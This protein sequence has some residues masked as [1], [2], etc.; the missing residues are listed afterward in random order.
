MKSLASFLFAAVLCVALL[1]GCEN[2]ELIRC[3]QDKD[4]L[5]EELN[6]TKEEIKTQKASIDELIDMTFKDTEAHQKQIEEMEGKL[7]QSQ[8][9][10]AA[11]KEAQKQ[12]RQKLENAIKAMLKVE[13]DKKALEEKVGQLEKAMENSTSILKAQ[14]DENEKLKARIAELESQLQAATTAP[15][16]PAS[17][18]PGN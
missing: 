8:A 18:H 17:E 5:T 2:T 14:A 16:A 13:A 6:A 1:A 9:E 12:D 4:N 7:Q 3:Q 10:T 11:V 15:A